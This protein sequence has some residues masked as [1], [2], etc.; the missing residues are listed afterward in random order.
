[1]INEKCNICKRPDVR[2]LVELGWNAGMDRSAIATAMGG[3]PSAPT[4]GKHLSEHVEEGYFTREVPVEDAKPL[5][6]RAMDIQ[7]VMIEEIERRIGIAQEK[8]AWAREN[9]NPDAD[10]S[11]WYDI[12]NKDEQA[13]IASIMKA[14]AIEDKDRNTKAGQKVDLFKMMA[15]G[16]APKSLTEGLDGPAE[17]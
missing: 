1:M 3:Y 10:W 14:Q 8:A 6:A 5:R 9:G 2:R 11:D 15:G 16:L 13:A 4:V 7:R 17:D 12:L